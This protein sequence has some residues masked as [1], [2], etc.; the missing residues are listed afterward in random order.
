MHV[1]IEHMH[2]FVWITADSSLVRKEKARNK[3]LPQESS[4]NCSGKTGVNIAYCMV[5]MSVQI[6]I[7]NVQVLPV[8]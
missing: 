4:R 1:T 5:G 7:N 6:K 3:H 2:H 8:T